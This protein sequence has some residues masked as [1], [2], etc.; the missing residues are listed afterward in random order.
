M[1]VLLLSIMQLFS[2]LAPFK[3]EV[4]HHRSWPKSQNAL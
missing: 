4:G 2:S 1:N 3:G